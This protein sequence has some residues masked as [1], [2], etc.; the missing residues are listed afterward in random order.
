MKTMR[1]LS[2]RQ[3][4]YKLTS[5]STDIQNSIEYGYRDAIILHSYQNFYIVAP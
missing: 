3:W 4:E 5:S 2:P 1:L